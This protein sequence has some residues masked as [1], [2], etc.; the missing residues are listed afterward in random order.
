MIDPMQLAMFRQSLPE[1]QR[2]EVHRFFVVRWDIV[3]ARFLIQ[4][5]SK[6][7]DRL[8]VLSA[9]KAYGFDK[10]Q[11]IDS[12]AHVDPALAMS[13][14]IDLDIPVILALIAREQEGDR[15]I[16][17]IIDG[18][19]RLYKAYRGGRISLLCYA[20]TPDEEQLCRL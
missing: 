19:A 17:I 10:S 16:P 4:Q 8:P 14:A 11:T 7:V 2:Y 1:S 13:D 3:A 18:L 15:T 5:T 12:W 6:R 9:A 20:L